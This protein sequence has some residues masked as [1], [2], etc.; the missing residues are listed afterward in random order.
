MTMILATQNRRVPPGLGQA[1]D[2]GG[3]IGGFISQI[4]GVVTGLLY[5]SAQRK[6]QKNERRMAQLQA[7]HAQAMLKL[8]SELQLE[9]LREK[10]LTKRG[11]IPALILPATIAGVTVAG[12]VLF[13]VMSRRRR[14]DK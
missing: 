2:I 6:F 11:I 5:A 12:G 13:I 3:A 8:Q 10:E 9:V 14:R 4:G 1:A 7:G